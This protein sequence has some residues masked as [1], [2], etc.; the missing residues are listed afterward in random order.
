MGEMKYLVVLPEIYDLGDDIGI[1]YSQG[2]DMN[3][4]SIRRGRSGSEFI[5][6]RKYDAGDGISRIHWKASA[7]SQ[8]LLVKQFQESN[9]YAF[10]IIFDAKMEHHMGSGTQSSLEKAVT[11]AASLA[12]MGTRNNFGIGIAFCGAEIT[13]V[14]IGYGKG[15]FSMILETLVGVQTGA[16]PDCWERFGDPVFAGK[17]C[18]IYFITGHIDGNMVDTLIRMMSQGREV[19]LFLLKL[20]SFGGQ[21]IMAEDRQKAVLRLRAVGIS[22]VM[23][24][25]Q[26]DLRLLFRGLEYGNC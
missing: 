11:L 12:A 14:P 21:G 6:V 16:G 4:G 19:I 22:V 23:V 25:R 10:M 13:Q 3:P 9:N 17:R 1:I 18:G 24:D 8:N 5:G 15:Q 20:E 2:L 26:T 7:K